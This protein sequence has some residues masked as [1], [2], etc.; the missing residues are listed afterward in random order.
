M[1]KFSAAKSLLGIDD[2]SQAVVTQQLDELFGKGG[3]QVEEREVAE[4]RA[5][6]TRKQ[7]ARWAKRTKRVHFRTTKETFDMLEEMVAGKNAALQGKGR[8]TRTEVIDAAIEL[9]YEHFSGKGNG[10]VS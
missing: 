9:Y 7:R 2:R 1:S 6:A 10:D 3:S 4:R 5:M 8:I